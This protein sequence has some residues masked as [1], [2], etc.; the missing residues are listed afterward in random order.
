MDRT[1]GRSSSMSAN[2]FPRRRHPNISLRPTSQEVQGMR[3]KDD[4]DDDDNNNKREWTKKRRG[5]NSHSTEE[6]SVGNE[7]DARMHSNN[8]ASSASDHNH[9]GRNV[10]DEVMIGAT[11][12]RRTRSA[13]VKRPHHSSVEEQSAE[14]ASP[15]SSNASL[16]K[17]MKAIGPSSSNQ[18]D[19]EI[20]IAE[21]LYSLRAS[22][23]HDYSSSQKVEASD[24]PPLSFYPAIDVEKKKVEGYS[25]S[26]FTLPPN[27]SVPELVVIEC[28]QP[29]KTEKTSSESPRTSGGHGIGSSQGPKQETEGNNLSPG[30]GCGDAVDG[31]SESMLD[32]DKHDCASTVRTCDDVSG[33]KDK[34]K[35]EIDLMATPPV[36]LSPEW[37]NLSRGED[38]NKVEDKIESFSK[39]EK[40]LGEIE[41]VKMKVDLEKSNEHNDLTTNHESGELGRNTEQPSTNPKLEKTAQCSAMSFS[42][43][44]SERPSSFSPLGYMPP[45][46]TA[47][48]TDNTTGLLT[49]PQHGNF[50]LSQPRPKRCVTHGY[51]ARN[52][53][54][55]QQCTKMNTLLPSAIGCGS[56]CDTKLSKVHSAESVVVGKQ[57]HKQS[58]VVSHNAEPEKGWATSSDFSLA[59]MK[60]SSG[61][62]NSMDMTQMKQLMLQQG[63]HS[64]SSAN[65]VHGPAFLIP[66]GQHQASVITGTS[67]P[68]GGVNNA[69]TAS[70]SNKF[71]S[72]PAV[73]LGAPTLPAVAAAMS[74]SYPN[75]AANDAPYMT[76]V[77]NSGYPFPFSTP[78]GPS[79]A[80]R[81]ASPA[82]STPIL[83][84]PLYSSQI[85]HPLQYPQQHPHSQ[86][87]VQ[88]SYLNASTSSVSSSSHKQS[89]GMQGNNNHIL[90]STTMQLQQSQKQHTSQP[91]L[92]KHE[93]GMARENAPSA[94]S[95][96]AYSQKHVFGQNF[97][98]P[99]QPLS[100]SLTP[101][102]TSDSVG[103]NSGNFGDKQQQ[104]LMGGLEHIPS[105]PHAISFA[106]YNG[107]SVPSNL[108]FST[109]AQNPVVFQSLPDIAWQGYHAA[110]TSHATQQK[111]YPI[112]EGNSGDSSSHRDDEKKATSG[113]P[114]TNGTTTLVFDNSAKNLSL[115][116]SPMNGNWPSRSITSTATTTS[117]P[118]SSNA[119]K[120][121][122][123]SQLLHLQQQHGMLQQQ[124]AMATRY[125][126]SSTNATSGANYF[127]SPVYSQTQTQ[128]KSS[129]KGSQSKICVTAP[130]SLVH[131]PCII[132]STAPTLQSFSQ[133]QGRVLQGHTQISFGGNYISSM[134]LQGQQLFNNNQSLGTTV[135]GIPPSGANLKTN[136]QG[137]KVSSSVNS[138]Q[139]QQT[140]N[141]S[142]GT[143][144]KS[145]PVCGRNVPSILSS[146]PSHLSE[147]KY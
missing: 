34:H 100:L 120:S 115:V 78:L 58:P 107:T 41:V 49:T 73:S 89:Q 75:L 91:H 1:R 19:I 93:T 81:G 12:P 97:P 145:S 30:C 60:R 94:P 42:V 118:L 90:S 37:D 29:A 114:S 72:S 112:I 54:M 23:N 133:D 82:Q 143:G 140:E 66:H 22:Q 102:A 99:V 62:A 40:T 103:G 28:Q 135:A 17:R 15:S 119:A 10:I 20:E 43:A 147:L 132:T 6:E 36:T 137:S 45:M 39:K 26:F 31:K 117:L 53:F 63:P 116:S 98:I 122:Q 83:N 51:I 38:S 56:M 69:S 128:S 57:F 126:A 96:T 13:S 109:V 84:G 2:A 104:T 74:F 121:Q 105:Q 146:C 33:G 4:N 35:F 111:M 14:A 61:P 139:M 127:T 9:R 46:G 44:V 64:G 134:P 55:H 138:S 25:P 144:Q 124:P 65:I 142:T 113:K 47:L 32:V 125:K 77:P 95:G 67:S 7:Q 136:S 101:S 52:I 79:A 76:I 86:P 11:V 8:T 130:D 21:L 106:A 131:N 80:I 3:L 50:A 92:R 59:A 24:S 123:A 18:E 16:P 87:L 85:F 71:Q 141:S 27:N 68:A 129:I 88:P 110:S 108:N 5:S 48:K 70:L